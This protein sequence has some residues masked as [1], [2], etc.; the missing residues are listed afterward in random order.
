MAGVARMS[1]S[2]RP[3]AAQQLA[4]VRLVNECRELGDD[5]VAWQRH[6]CQGLATITGGGYVAC[7]ASPSSPERATTL[8]GMEADGP[9]QTSDFESRF[10]GWLRNP[11]ADPNNHFVENE[12]FARFLALREPVFAGL[13]S[14]LM[15]DDEWEALPY[16]HE[17]WRPEGLDD[18]LF[19][20]L[21]VPVVGALFT[22]TETAYVGEPRFRRR[23][24]N[25]LAALLRELHLHLGRALLLTTQ[26]NLHGLS[27]RRRE[28]LSA[29]LEG[30]SEKQVALRLGI[31][32]TTVHDH[33]K[34]LHSHFGV[35][36]RAEL[37]A[38]FLRRY[39]NRRS[40]GEP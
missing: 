21:W 19:G 32:V 16:T 26:P 38:Y 34:A 14:D 37:L 31:H 17:R 8:T 36:S 10:R 11:Q 30:D 3:T 13:R 29:L 2:H 28:V 25:L 24:T 6:L 1:K 4:V 33:V 9:W 7:G 12:P 40:E 18:G 20:R 5:A 22:V 39:R 23:H 35:N 27:P 15:P